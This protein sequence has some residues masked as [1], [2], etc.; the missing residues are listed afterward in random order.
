ML[1]NIISYD[2]IG[3]LQVHGAPPGRL[4][5]GGLRPAR[6][7]AEGPA[8]FVRH[9][10]CVFSWF[11]IRHTYFEWF[12]DQFFLYVYYVYIYVY[13]YIY[14]YIPVLVFNNKKKAQ[15]KKAAAEP[16]PPKQLMTAQPRSFEGSLYMYIYIYIYIM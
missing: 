16:A 12:P 4:R 11:N 8:V 10:A 7:A 5:G 13:I 6:A 3:P 9:R 15:T 1:Y 14:I 2:I